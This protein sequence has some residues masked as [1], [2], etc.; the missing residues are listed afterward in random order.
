MDPLLSWDD[1]AKLIAEMKP[2]DR[3]K[4][5]LLLNTDSGCYV[6]FTGIG[7]SDDEGDAP[8]HPVLEESDAYYSHEG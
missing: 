3:K 2:E 1:L 5:V 7:R 6:A 4:P 8:D